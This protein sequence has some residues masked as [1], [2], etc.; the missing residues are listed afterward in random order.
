[1]LD[2]IHTLMRSHGLI[3]IGLISLVLSFG[4]TLVY[5]FI[6]NQALIKEYKAELK[7]FQEKMKANPEQAAE[8]QKQSMSINLKLMKESFKPMLYTIIPFFAIFAWLKYVFIVDGVSLIVLPLPFW[9]GHLG[10]LGT[11]IIFSLVFST[12]SRKLLKVV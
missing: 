10:W 3:A 5:K 6:T 1:M 12:L 2:A 8:I 7:K 4:F 9:E 11:Y